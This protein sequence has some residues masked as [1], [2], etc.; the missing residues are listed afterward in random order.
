MPSPRFL[1]P[2]FSTSW[3]IHYTYNMKNDDP[4]VGLGADDLQPGQRS[5]S[6]T[7]SNTS[8]FKNFRGAVARY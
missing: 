6:T 3:R 7:R 8:F 4:F 5:I 1:T 2:E